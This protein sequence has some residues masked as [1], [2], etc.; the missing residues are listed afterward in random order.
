MD[1]APVW[2]TFVAALIISLSYFWSSI[3][4][5]FIEF[6]ALGMVPGT[7]VILSYDQILMLG[8]SFFSIWLVL[9]HLSHSLSKSARRHK[10]ELVS[11]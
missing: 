7:T 4:R 9:E 3:E 11:S 10:A 1:Y 2:S 8:L 6:M 5:P